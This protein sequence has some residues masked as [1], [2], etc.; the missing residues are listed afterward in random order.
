MKQFILMST[1]L[2]TSALLSSN[3][4]AASTEVTWKDY[5][6]YFDVNEGN[7]TRSGFKD[8]VTER[9]GEHFTKLATKLP[10]GQTLKIEVTDVDLAGHVRAGSMNS[11]RIIK[12]SYPPR[13]NFSYQLLDADGKE[14]KAEDVVVRDLGYLSGS[15]PIKYRR[16]LFGYEQKMLDDWFRDTFSDMI[17]K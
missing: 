11:T 12:S 6:S 10:E 2:V 7:H 15:L 9:I 5:K 3:V 16:D 4:M 8:L 13:M 1:L 14:I 17:V